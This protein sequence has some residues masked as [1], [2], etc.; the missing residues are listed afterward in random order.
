MDSSVCVVLKAKHTLRL[1]FERIALL[2]K[3]RA[4]LVDLRF[5]LAAAML[6]QVAAQRADEAT[7]T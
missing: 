2:E 7:R 6:Q 1:Y 5:S 3:E 4:K